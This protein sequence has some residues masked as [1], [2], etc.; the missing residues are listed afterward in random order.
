MRTTERTE[1]PG[2]V[3]HGDFRHSFPAR[4]IGRFLA[5]RRRRMAVRELQA[6]PDSLLKDI[7]VHRHEIEEVVRYGRNLARFQAPAAEP[8]PA[9]PRK[10]A[11]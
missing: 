6:L 9:P 11:A 7:G 4:V 5:W 3:V 2:T 1:N 8:V 10:A